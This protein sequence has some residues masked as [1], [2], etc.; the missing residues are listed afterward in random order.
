MPLYKYTAKTSPRQ[1]IEAQIEAASQQEAVNKIN[2]LGYFPLSVV[3]KGGLA[4]SAVGWGLRIK[5]EKDLI[6]FTRQLSS[7][8]D[9]GV[10]IINALNLLAGQS[11]NKY[12]RS[13]L[14][15][16]ISQIKDGKPFSEGLAS[17]PFL[18]SNLYS[19]MIQ[20]AEASGNLGVVLERLANFLEKEGELKDTL[21]SGLVYPAFIVGV[22][23]LTV[24]TLLVFVIPRIVNMFEDM[25]QA[26]PIPTKV[27]ISVSGY[28]R[29][30]WWM[31]LAAII[32]FGFLFSRF[33]SSVKGKVVWDNLKLKVPFFGEIILKDET[34]RFCRT[35]SLLLSSGMPILPAL[36]IAYSVLGNETLK[37]WVTRFRGE[38]SQGASLSAAFRQADIF[39]D[40]VKSIIS[41]GEESGSLDKALLRIADDYEKDVDRN[42]KTA[43]RLVE[44]IIILAMGLIVGFIVLSM[45]LPIFQI[46]LMVR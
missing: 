37:G 2:Q 16:I 6:I 40:F 30:Y 42:M 1:I 33:K 32:F 8:I 22:G 9:S 39:P 3:E 4:Q 14:S 15:D 25:G 29:Q 45:L 20:T 28:L 35:L 27:L 17:H 36:D 12:I 23:V 21:R 41:V 5:P 11:A 10:N 19:A 24:A 46:N 18:F 7:L 31:I 34:G 26:L 43:L 44:P 38:I 13:V